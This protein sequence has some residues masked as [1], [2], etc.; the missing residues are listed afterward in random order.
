MQKKVNPKG[1]IENIYR[2]IRGG[3]KNNGFGSVRSAQRSG[4]PPK[5]RNYD[6]GFRLVRTKR[7]KLEKVLYKK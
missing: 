3:S 7:T 2:V 4:D 5:E 6:V 1:L